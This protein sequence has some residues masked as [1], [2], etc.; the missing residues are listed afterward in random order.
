MSDMQGV[1]QRRVLTGFYWN[2]EARL[3]TFINDPPGARGASRPSLSL[4]DGAAPP[5][6]A[7]A[8]CC[9]GLLQ[10]DRWR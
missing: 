4:Q 9:H 10:M 2:P 7:P 3:L 1:R 5:P 8:E 6:S